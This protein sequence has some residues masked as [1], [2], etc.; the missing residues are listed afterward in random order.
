MVIHIRRM[1]VEFCNKVLVEILS[2]KECKEAH[3]EFLI[4]EMWNEKVINVSKVTLKQLIVEREITSECLL[5]RFLELG[6]PL[7]KEDIKMAIKRLKPSQVHLFKYIVAKC[8]PADLDELCQAAVRANRMTFVLSLV[9]R[10]ATLPSHGSDLLLQALSAEDYDGAL[11]LAGKFTKAT[12]DKL[13]LAT[14]MESNIVN[15]PELIKVLVDA[16]LSPNGSGRKTPIAAVMAKA[17]SV[18]KKIDMICLLLEVG[19]DCGHLCQIG[20]STTTP[21]HVATELALQ[22]GA[23]I[24]RP[25][26]LVNA[27]LHK[28]EELLIIIYIFL[29]SSVHAGGDLRLIGSVVCSPTFNSSKIANDRGESPLHQA[30]KSHWKRELSALVL[31]ALLETDLLDPSKRDQSGKRPLDYLSRSDSR[32]SMLEEAM[33][34]FRPE[35]SQQKKKQKK[36]KGKGGSTCTSDGSSSASISSQKVV[37]KVNIQQPSFESSWR[38]R[39]REEPKAEQTYAELTTPNKVEF[40]MKRVMAKDSSYFKVEVEVTVTVS[41]DTASSPEEEIPRMLE[42]RPSVDGEKRDKSSEEKQICTTDKN[43]ERETAKDVDEQSPDDILAILAEHVDGFD[44]DKLPWEVEVTAKVVKFFKDRKKVAPKLREAAAITIHKLAKGKRND[45]LSKLV[46]GEK[47]LRLYEAK[48]TKAARILWEKAI[49]Y[50]AKLTGPSAIP[51]YSEVIRVWEV[52]LDHDN[53][54]RRI[55]YCTQQIEKSHLRGHDASVRWALM[56]QKTREPSEDR[57]KIRGQEKTDIPVRYLLPGTSLADSEHQ[58]IPAASTKDDEYNVTT[59]YSFDTIA[60]K[61]MLLGTNDRRDFPFK[62]WQKEHEIIKL[63]PKEAILLLGRSGTGKT[64]CCLYRLWNEFKNFWNPESSTFGWKI[65]RRRLIPPSIVVIPAEDAEAKGDQEESGESETESSSTEE[66]CT[67]TTKDAPSAK[68]P[69]ECSALPTSDATSTSASDM[70]V[71]PVGE[72]VEIIEEDLHQVFITKNYVL[73]DQ[74]KKRFYNMAAACDFLEEHMK[75]EGTA[76]SN[77]LSRIENCA[78]PLFLTARQFYILLDN[79]LCDG[80]AFFKRDEDGNL[81]V[82]ITSLDYDHEDPDIL[83]DLEQSDSEDEEMERT[84]S[85]KVPSLSKGHTERWTEVTALY[86]KEF[87]WPTVSH[88]CG[89]SSKDFDPLLVWI[90]IQSFIKGS[91]S[92]LRKGGCLSLEEYKQIGNRMAPNFSSH[93]DAIYKIFLKYQKYQ[94]NQRHHNYLFD[95]CDLVLHLFNRLKDVPDVPW[96]IHSLYIDEVQDF[97]QAELA[98][99]IHCCRDPNSMFFTGDTA[100]SIMRG[101]AFRFQDLRSSFHRLHSK[102]PAINVPQKPH[103]LTINFRSHSGILKLAGSIID[104]IR[105][106]FKDSIDHLPDDEGMFPGPTPV[107]LES[108]KIGDLALLLSTN[109]RE[110]SAIEFGAHQVILVQSK[111]AKDNLPSILKGAIVLTIFEA[112]GLEFDDVLL[113]N[114]FTD[115]MVSS[116]HAYCFTYRMARKFRGWP[117]INNFEG[118]IFED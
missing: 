108:C 49:S 21:L 41:Y 87:I 105:E 9:D 81:K 2:R 42:A 102:I 34:K 25:S 1:T 61:S 70:S 38:T 6:L 45:H 3:L 47:S 39:E 69:D 104:L 85:T 99:F 59:F 76:L 46:S 79:S 26:V 66:E 33:R 35:L 31:S 14:L 5:Q 12:M 90:E 110:S 89:I 103:N 73:C 54:D 74:M 20:K 111:E 55:K 93:R 37:E 32:V 80:Q 106:F 114:F 113:Y 16:G 116:A 72:S 92:A 15:C 18:T 11:A 75:H 95:E 112:K 100:Q 94:Q 118:K 51:V 40:H 82:K 13:D 84:S 65:P 8:N 109:K 28:G 30:I 29:F 44:F 22:S 107:L 10:G 7:T 86:F 91:E 57:G 19:E 68:S 83:L 97:T 53:L 27:S 64:T 67:D 63:T 36:K 50:S 56:P 58:F 88:Q 24:R 71:F 101:I 78:F 117:S 60:F 115:S 4:S 96:S 48:L 77:D 62:E 98:I 17:I 23:C 52:V 43:E